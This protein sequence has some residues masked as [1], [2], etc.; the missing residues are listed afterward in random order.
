MR[1][2]AIPGIHVVG[3]PAEAVI[4]DISGFPAVSASLLLLIALLLLD[5]LL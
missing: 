2:L 5:S 1:V 4:Y 3:F